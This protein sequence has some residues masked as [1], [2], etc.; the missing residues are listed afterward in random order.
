MS[1]HRIRIFL[2]RRASGGENPAW[3]EEIRMR[4][5]RSELE[6]VRPESLAE[7]KSEL[8][9]AV[10]EK[11]DVI[12]SVGGDGTV[13]TLIQHLGNTETALLVVPARTA[14]DLARELGLVGR[15]DRAIHAIRSGAPRT[16]DLIRINQTLMATN[17]GLGLA[18]AVAERV[19]R[20]RSRLPAFKKVMNVLHHHTYTA[21]L[22]Y[23]LLSPALRYL[24]LQVECAEFQGEIRSPLLMINNQPSLAGSFRI[25]PGTSNQDGQ[26]NVSF[27]AH[28]RRRDFLR[29][30]ASIKA[31]LPPQGDPDFVSFET[32]NIFIRARAADDE[33]PFFGDGEVFERNREFRAEIQPGALRVYGGGRAS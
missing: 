21:V 29:A 20:L 6:F 28:R 3:M 33:L 12:V 5:F 19:N 24:H 30:L 4:L 8:A 32:K 2:N 1:P 18:G 9:R 31:G 23:E 25:A 15:I 27:F 11:V 10:A 26:F 13:N 16:I 22:G 14:N 7:L 17:G